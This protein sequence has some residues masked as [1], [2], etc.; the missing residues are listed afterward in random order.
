[1]T[2]KQLHNAICEYIKYQYPDVYFLSDPS[3]IKMSIGM[4]VQLKKGRSKHAQLDIVILEPRKG[5]N[6]LIIEVKRSHSEVFKKDKLTLR[7]NKHIDKQIASIKHLQSKG[8]E[9]GYVF[10]F[11]DA[12]AYIHTYMDL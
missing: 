9:A 10:G 12:I 3:G 5:F 6:G 8:Y 7:K 1:M 4:A 2:E 11:D